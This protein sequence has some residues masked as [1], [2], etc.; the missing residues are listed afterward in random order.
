MRFALR[1]PIG[2]V[3]ST[4]TSATVSREF[5]ASGD[6]LAL[7]REVEEERGTF[8]SVFTDIKNKLEEIGRTTAMVPL[9]G[10]R[11][12]L[13]DNSTAASVFVAA[14]G[15]LSILGVVSTWALRGAA[16]LGGFLEWIV[17]GPALIY[18]FIIALRAGYGVFEALGIL[19]A[20]NPLGAVIAA[21]S[22]LVVLS[23]E[24]YQHWR[25]LIDLWQKLPSVSETVKHTLPS[26][27]GGDAEKQETTY[28]AFGNALPRV[29]GLGPSEP[30]LAPREGP[31]RAETNHK[32][33]VEFNNSP[34]GMRVTKKES[35]SGADVDTMIN[36][37]LLGAIP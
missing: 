1:V 36:Y 32:V 35:D 37:G 18:D 29:A 3:K 26:W 11:D 25:D 4:G 23:Y 12:L 7:R 6:L 24:L 34:R 30:I 22:V 33:T 20:S 14:L 19:F 21:V 28:D 5:A 9:R 15:G 17:S 2:E 31:A 16:A 13:R 10:L 8:D 27:L